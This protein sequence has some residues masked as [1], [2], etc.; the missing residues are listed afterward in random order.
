MVF[1]LRRAWVELE[2]AIVGGSR[3][4]IIHAVQLIAVQGES[5]VVYHAVGG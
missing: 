2:A 1:V 3:Y 4:R 5:Q